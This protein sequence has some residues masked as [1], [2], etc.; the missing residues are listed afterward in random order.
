MKKRIMAVVLAGFMIFEAGT[1]S[2]SAE[3]VKNIEKSENVMQE[4]LSGNEKSESENNV[5]ELT[6]FPEEQMGQTEDQREDPEIP[7]ENGIQKE[8][9]ETPE[10]SVNQKEDPETQKESESPE[11]T[12]KETGSDVLM[13]KVQGSEVFETAQEKE[14]D[15]QSEEKSMYEVGDEL[16]SE[17]YEYDLGE[18][19]ENSFDEFDVDCE[20]G[21]LLS[22]TSEKRVK[23]NFQ[24][25][26]NEIF[27]DLYENPDAASE[28]HVGIY[29]VKEIED[30]D[31]DFED[32]YRITKVIWSQELEVGI[33]PV[34]LER[35]FVLSKGAYMIVFMKTGFDEE[36]VDYTFSSKDVT[37]YATSVS[38]PEKLFMDMDSTAQIPVSDI[39]P[40]NA[41][42]GIT[43]ESTDERIAEVN[44][45]G[46]V[47]GKSPGK[48]QILATLRNGT[49]YAC[50]VYVENPQFSAK[51]MY[52]TKG[53][54][55]KLNLKYAY[56]PVKWK[57]SDT[58]IV[59]VDQKGNITAKKAGTA[60][61]S[62]VT[63]KKTIK[64]RVQVET[65]KISRKKETIA[66]GSS[67]ILEMTG[68]KQNVKWSSSN[69]KIAT[70]KNGTVTGKKTGKATIT[71]RVGEKDYNCK[72]TIVENKLKTTSIK[73]AVKTKKTVETKKKIKNIKWSSS[74]KKVATVKAGV[75][76]AKKAG[77]AVITAKIKNVNYTCK[78]TVENPKLNKKSINLEHGKSKTLK[79]AKTTMKVKW[80]SSDSSIAKVTSK[81]KVTGKKQGRAVITAK[82]GGKEFTC[83]VR[84]RGK[85]PKYKVSMVRETDPA[86]SAALLLL[87]NTGTQPMRIYSKNARL[88]DGTYYAYNRNLVLISFDDVMNHDTI[89]P[90]S[91]VDIQPGQEA[92]LPFI[93]DGS[94]TWYDY[95]STI[96]FEFSYDGERYLASN[97]L[98]YGFS[99][100]RK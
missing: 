52:I 30:E 76:T 85:K 95:K 66:K 41:L 6:E 20:V 11:S 46:K 25:S 61:I 77:T 62:A 65:P 48:C 31:A 73:M 36:W 18:E 33:E 87:K 50:N 100:T 28:M 98:Y 67:S 35:E 80:S 38:I 97:S 21:Y 10:E 79:V 88:I 60:V 64:C 94:P 96:R 40:K 45:S 16:W 29:R 23:F 63:G 3:T 70:V 92:Y 44:S 82:V 91:W 5:E 93:V 8:D 59:Q 81:G 55:K 49:E 22:I 1:A 7:E 37:Q 78:V 13:E 89:T 58:Q 12:Q 47:T 99:Y 4:E 15:R 14:I 74:N 68:T 84:V 56:Q 72:V 17:E 42:K 34:I 32:F 26:I 90:V 54:S 57:S 83:K 86:M 69:T 24:L 39:E 43:W 2:V 27:A 19:V 9:P 75:V 53:E 71:A 51:T